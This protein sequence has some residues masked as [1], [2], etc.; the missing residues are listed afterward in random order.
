[1]PV[2]IRANLTAIPQGIDSRS[3]DRIVMLHISFI[4]LSIGS[5]GDPVPM[6]LYFNELAILQ[7]FMNSVGNASMQLICRQGDRA[8]EIGIFKQPAID[9]RCWEAM[10]YKGQQNLKT[11]FQYRATLAETESKVKEREIE[12]KRLKAELQSEQD[13]IGDVIKI[14]TGNLKVYDA[15]LKDLATAEAKLAA[16]RVDVIDEVYKTQLAEMQNRLTRYTKE[17]SSAQTSFDTHNRVLDSG[18][19]LMDSYEIELKKAKDAVVVIDYFKN[20]KFIPTDQ[21]NAIDYI[22]ASAPNPGNSG[23]T[24][25]VSSNYTSDVKDESALSLSDVLGYFSSFPGYQSALGLQRKLHVAADKLGTEGTLEVQC[26]VKAPHE[27]ECVAHQVAYEHRKDGFFFPKPGPGNENRF[28]QGY[29]NLNLKTADGNKNCFEL[30]QNSY[31]EIKYRDTGKRDNEIDSD[32][33]S[34]FFLLQRNSTNA[35]NYSLPQGVLHLEDLV[36]GYRVDMSRN[37]GHW[38]SLHKRNYVFQINGDKVAENHDDD[39]EGFISADSA[40]KAFELVM[41]NGP[42]KTLTDINLNELTHDTSGLAVSLPGNIRPVYLKILL[43]EK[44][45]YTFEDKEASSTAI[46]KIKKSAKPLSGDLLEDFVAKV[47]EELKRKSAEFAHRS[48]GCDLRGRLY[49]KSLGKYMNSQEDEMPSFLSSSMICHLNGRSLSAPG[50]LGKELQEYYNRPV[51]G[52]LQHLGAFLQDTRIELGITQK[53]HS[54]PLLRIGDLHSVRCRLVLVGGGSLPLSDTNTSEAISQKL[55]RQD[56][57]APPRLLL[58]KSYDPKSEGVFSKF[59]A[60]GDSESQIIIRGNPL[61]TKTV[62]RIIAPPS[63][64]WQLAEWSKMMDKKDYPDLTIMQDI[65]SSNK[66]PRYTLLPEMK[67]NVKVVERVKGTGNFDAFVD[68]NDSI[69]YLVDPMAAYFVIEPVKLYSVDT[70]ESILFSSPADV[71]K[72]IKEAY[73]AQLKKLAEAFDKTFFTPGKEPTCNFWGDKKPGERKANDKTIKCWTLE[74]KRVVETIEDKKVIETGI[75]IDVTKRTVSIML[76]PGDDIEFA[77]R[78]FTTDKD[79]MDSLYYGRKVHDL[80]KKGKPGKTNTVVIAE[81]RFRTIYAVGKPSQNPHLEDMNSALPSATSNGIDQFQVDRLSQFPLD[82]LIYQSILS[83]GR[84]CKDIFLVSAWEEILDDV[85][86]DEIEKDG[87]PIR[88]VRQFKKVFSYFDKGFYAYGNNVKPEERKFSTEKTD[89]PFVWEA[90]DQTGEL[91]LNPTKDDKK[92][93]LYPNLRGKYL[94]F[95]HDIGSSKAMLARYRMGGTSRFDVYFEEGR[96]SKKTDVFSA[97]DT[98]WFGNKKNGYDFLLKAT[99]IPISPKIFSITPLF[100]TNNNNDKKF[101]GVRVHLERPWFSSGYGEQLA[102]ITEITNDNSDVA[103][104]YVSQVGRDSLVKG[105]GLSGKSMFSPIPTDYQ[106]TLPVSGKLVSA[107]ILVIPVQFDNRNKRWYSDIP[108]D[109]GDLKN[110]YCPFVKLVLSR[111]QPSAVAGKELS[112]PVMCDFFQVYPQR[113]VSVGGSNGTTIKIQ[114][115]SIK[116]G[117]NEKGE[118]VILTQIL[119]WK[120]GVNMVMAKQFDGYRVEHAES[121]GPPV[122]ANYDGNENFTID[123]GNDKIQ[124]VIIKEFELYAKSTDD[125]RTKRL[126]YSYVIPLNQR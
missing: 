110:A 83:V 120:V 24:S 15:L 32:Y 116:K 60:L 123:Y 43:D 48:L 51:K 18:K 101:K 119:Y 126:L 46:L 75:E 80:F 117:L 111:F 65:A 38:Q 102:V 40:S 37:N 96:N 19:K 10:N 50:Y 78:S 6:K 69:P 74:V 72:K 26:D 29:L 76:K 4:K 41:I 49:Y 54:L 95:R 103:L 58:P 7:A 107:K 53:N 14:E 31:E 9:K 106:L 3:G 84:V 108:L 68:A 56:P 61:E 17:Y 20:N 88:I 114:G 79:Q 121:L 89:S 34:G 35:L 118:E 87:S 64:N 39:D 55:L 28:T 86:E 21:D 91:D 47:N 113:T 44:Y 42:D 12:L 70:T 27:I 71:K 57:I 73:D 52:Q 82:V 124:A 63:I 59:M 5:S 85:P 25:T 36:Q 93:R 99:Q 23:S 125:I 62:T 105:S 8:E 2:V 109:G 77:I 30:L 112:L 122:E 11:F 1:M 67:N 90:K 104:Q 94:A 22:L 33:T 92:F 115:S 13:R 98:Q 100:D 45:E 97:E 16:E 66:I 81:R